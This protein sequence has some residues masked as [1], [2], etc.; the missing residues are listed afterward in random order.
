MGIDFV[1]IPGMIKI[2]NEQYLPLS[3]KLDP[4]E[5]LNIRK[6]I[7]LA[8]AMTFKPDF[9]IVDKAP[10]GMK[11][12]VV[13]T[14]S[15]LRDHCSSC[16]SILGLRDIMDSAASTV[17]EWRSKGIYDVMESLYDEIWI[18]GSR[19]LYDPIREYCIPASIA[20]KMHFTGYIPRKVPSPEQI[21]NARTNFGI[22]DDEKLI[23]VTPGGGGDGH[24]MLT[25]FLRAF[26]P[27][28]G[29]IPE[30]TR[31]VIVTGPFISQRNYQD[32]VSQCD[33]KQ[34]ITLRFHRGMESL[35]GAA[36]VVVSMGGYNTICEI[37]SQRKPF[38]I[39]PRTIPREEQ[40]IRAS[41]LSSNGFC[42]FIDPRRPDLDAMR[43][44]I[45]KLLDNG[46]A[47]RDKMASFPFMALDV[48]R[49]RIS[50]HWKG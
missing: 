33:E 11:R 50:E 9:F 23:L 25:S 46:V 30:R 45:L 21:R 3:I 6:S 40:L 24:P 8:T 4:S 48:I 10:L 2:T 13:D 47:Y 37:A 12:E 41:V 31:V 44:K 35:I 15:W 19:E 36:Q 39:I 32:L 17:D 26:D 34:Y 1:R 28:R 22:A 7:I 20:S 38:L 29:G 27:A 43:E 14:L 49:D 18:Y 5:V 16:T 42:D